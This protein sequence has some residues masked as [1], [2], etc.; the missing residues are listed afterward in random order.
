[1]L[2]AIPQY[3]EIDRCSRLTLR[4]FKHEYLYKSRP[5]VI[6]DAMEHWKARSTWTL[7]FFK[8]RY[9]DVRITVFKFESDQYQPNKPQTFRMSEFIEAIQEKDWLSYPYYVRDDWRLFVDHRELLGDY[10]TP[11][12][13]FDWFTFVPPFM[14]LVY[15]RVFIGPKGAITPL[16]DDI[17]GTHAWLGQLV[18][19]KRWFL[20]PP[21]Q[22]DLL[23]DY[24][25]QAHNPD[26]ERFPLFEKAKPFECIIHPGDIIFV[27]GGWSHEVISLDATL[28]ITHNYMGPGCF[29][30]SL[31]N[32]VKTKV[33]Q[34]LLRQRSSEF[35]NA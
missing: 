10:E 27:P 8:T 35:R 26:L 12:Y 22:R 4:E 31:T 33:I 29:K 23:Y 13:F 5:V 34:R 20:F 24:T 6:T 1:M 15:P 14:R 25:V 30:T 7:D 11:E 17:W 18:G 16:H 28:S 19:R 32:S 9:G 2:T 21:D 3:Q